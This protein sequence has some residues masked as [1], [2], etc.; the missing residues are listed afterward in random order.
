MSTVWVDTITTRWEKKPE[1]H[2]AVV[3]SFLSFVSMT[4]S[5]I[6]KF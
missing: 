5:I 2:I 4:S 1:V 6:L 3:K